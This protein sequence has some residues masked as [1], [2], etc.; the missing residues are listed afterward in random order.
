LADQISF[1]VDV[2]VAA[3]LGIY[4]LCVG[5]ILE[6]LLE[7]A[8]DSWSRLSWVIGIGA[9]LFCFWPLWGAGLEV[10]FWPCFIPLIGIPFEK[11]WRQ[12]NRFSQK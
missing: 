12:K 2:S 9:L 3:Y 7:G 11:F 4:L 5:V 10:I 8:F 6:K 1:V